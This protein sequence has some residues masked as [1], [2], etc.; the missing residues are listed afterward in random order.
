MI[1]LE[2]IVTAVQQVPIFAL[3]GSTVRFDCSIVVPPI[4]TPPNITLNWYFSDDQ[5]NIVNV[6]ARNR[7]IQF[8]REDL[9]QSLILDNVTFGDT[10]SYACSIDDT[11]SDG[12]SIIL[13]VVE[14]QSVSQ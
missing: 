7:S 14:G 10:G 2:V 3:P 6:M 8:D 4:S 1:T 11:I 12:S 9:R 5:G 13:I